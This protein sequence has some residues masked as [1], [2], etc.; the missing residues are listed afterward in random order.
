MT[1]PLVLIVDDV[2]EVRKL[3]SKA[4]KS[5]DI[6]ILEASNGAEAVKIINQ[7]KNLDPI[8]LDI[9]LPDYNGFQIMEKSKPIKEK[10]NFKVCFISGKKEKSD[11]MKAI[12][13]GG[14]DY[15]VKPIFPDAIIEKV[16][17]L[18]KAPEIKADYLPLKVSLK[19]ILQNSDITPDMSIT[20]LTEAGVQ[21]RSSAAVRKEAQILVKSAKLNE[22]TGFDEAILM[23]VNSCN[24]ISHGKYFL[25]CRFV[26]ASE[27]FKREIRTLCIRGNFLD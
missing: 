9:M 17:Q 12:S 27:E 25:D 6:D 19:G 21:I 5:K 3:I 23:K 11:V 7:Y 10:R 15:I 2:E 24:R 8:L 13:L 22:Y 14:D 4:L 18:I 1:R 20:E 26:G 16:G